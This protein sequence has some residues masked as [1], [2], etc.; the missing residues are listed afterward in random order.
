[1]SVEHSFLLLPFLPP[2]K[3]LSMQINCFSDNSLWAQILLLLFT[4]VFVKAQAIL[5][6][7]PI[8]YMHLPSIGGCNNLTLKVHPW[9]H[10]LPR[11]QIP[12]SLFITL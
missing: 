11:N 9:L 2:F 4:N 6:I 1:M 7:M 10:P 12:N 3:W 8:F 5:A